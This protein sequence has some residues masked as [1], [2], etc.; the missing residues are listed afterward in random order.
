[1][2]RPLSFSRALGWPVAA[3]L[4]AVAAYFVS[5]FLDLRRSRVRQAKQSEAWN[6]ELAGLPGGPEFLNVLEKLHEAADVAWKDGDLSRL[7]GLEGRRWVVATRFLGE[8]HWQTSDAHWAFDLARRAKGLL[9]ADLQE[10]LSARATAEEIR[11][12]DQ[13]EWDPTAVARAEV[14]L[15][16][17][18]RLVDTGHPQYASNLH[19][20][21]YARY[22]AGDYLAARE[23]FER[24]T[25]LRANTL[26]RQHPDYAA[27]LHYVGMMHFN[28]GRISDAEPLIEEAL[29]VRRAAFGDHHVEVAESLFHLSFLY[30]SQDLLVKAE[31]NVQEVWRFVQQEYSPEHQYYAYCLRELGSLQLRM[32]RFREAEE[33]IKRAVEVQRLTLGTEHP[34]FTDPMLNLGSLYYQTGRYREGAEIFEEVRE[35]LDGGRGNPRR[36]ATALS[37]IAEFHEN[38]GEI[39]EAKALHHEALGIYQGLG[40][41]RA[42]IE[43]RTALGLLDRRLGNTARGLRYLEEA[44]QSRKEAFGEVSTSYAWGLH[45][46][47]YFYRLNSDY[48]QAERYFLRAIEVSTGIEGAD[49]TTQ[50][51][52]L[53]ALGDL[54][55]GRGS[56]ARSMNFFRQA[57]DLQEE[58]LG[59]DHPD[60]AWILRRIADLHYLAEDLQLAEPLYRRAAELIRA[61]WGTA[62]PWYA[63]ALFDLADLEI[64]QDHADNAEKLL[65]EAVKIQQE[66]LGPNSPSFAGALSRL[67]EF[68]ALSGNTESAKGL[69]GQS[70]EILAKALG[71]NAPAYSFELADAAW[72]AR[73]GGDLETAARFLAES[74]SILDGLGGQSPALGSQLFALAEV[75]EHLGQPEEAQGLYRRAMDH[76][77]KS[78]ALTFSFLSEER[79]LTFVRGYQRR[80]GAFLSLL[81]R[82]GQGEKAYDVILAWKGLVFRQQR[83]LRQLRQEPG[84]SQLF[85]ELERVSRRIGFLSF[86]SEAA[87]RPAVAAHRELEELTSRLESIEVELARRSK[88]YSRA[89]REASK[90]RSEIRSSLPSATALIDFF[91]FR[92]SSLTGERERRPSVNTVSAFVVTSRGL[93]AVELCPE[94]DL[95][96]AIDAWRK[97]HIEDSAATPAEQQAAAQALRRLI[98]EPLEPFI[99]GSSTILISPDGAVARVPFA[100]LPT[101]DGERFLIED[102]TLSIVPM[103]QLLPQ[104]LSTNAGLS[105]SEP[106]ML[107]IGGIDYGSVEAV[108]AGEGIP[109][110]PIAAAMRTLRRDAAQTHGVTFWPRLEGARQESLEV[111]DLFESRFGRKS[112]RLGQGLEA[113]PASED[114]FR[115]EAPGSQYLHL[116]TH[117]FFASEA[118]QSTID[119]PEPYARQL[120]PAA[121]ER[122]IFGFHPGLLSGVVLAGANRPGAATGDAGDDGI[123]TATEVAVLDLARIK[124]VVLS[125]CE[126]GLGRVAGG[127]GVLGL[128]RAFQLAG[129]PSVVASMWKVDDAATR[130]L[131]TRFYTLLWNSGLPVAEALRQAQLE[132]L[133]G[134]SFQPSQR[135]GPGAIKSVDRSL[136][137]VE[138]EAGERLPPFYW[139]SFVLSGD[140][141]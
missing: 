116:A 126:T 32:G 76:L 117:G 64:S 55:Q 53:V 27:S 30:Q 124:L 128:Q 62:H 89:S 29:A 56:Y 26:G 71:T 80:I 10:L 15:V 41:D 4:L 87:K 107:V 86:S 99:A 129:A 36:M 82:T 104:I 139:A 65:G 115:R 22:L 5:E 66:Q 34:W 70:L 136:L 31:E 67:A 14:A 111:A 110:V 1:M 96:L 43:P 25:K 18:A 141:R 23:D 112:R 105:Q 51:S 69:F 134:M 38:I 33:S 17:A 109:P 58:R 127:E 39:E 57:L 131:V 114:A 122:K 132:L 78:T 45:S 24:A 61:H 35:M 103:A 92:H 95:S 12:M 84:N 52:I 3:A 100:A 42:T 2:K 135:R 93:E 108:P 21:G 60:L 120:S 81:L 75:T 6:A 40:D 130:A 28:A 119:S 13:G 101:Q 83:Q 125:A 44:L 68:H 106:K 121:V 102:L 91:V 98:W 137:E 46:L 123:L 48:E 118:M 140:W 59:T 133:E 72:A 47:G 54:Y 97:S 50:I 9:K 85:S 88:L 74:I 63:A 20:I 73:R 138:T 16:S 19:A 113:D 11:A 90:V 77:Q 94:G 49:N 79:Q 37:Q 7:L 8:S